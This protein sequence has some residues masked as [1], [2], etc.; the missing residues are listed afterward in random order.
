[1]LELRQSI[2]RK[3]PRVILIHQLVKSHW[4]GLPKHPF[5]HLCKATGRLGS[6]LKR[7]LNH[8]LPNHWLDKVKI[9]GKDP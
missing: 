9:V 4:P 3:T 7:V 5:Q 6:C 1:M 8:C 2:L